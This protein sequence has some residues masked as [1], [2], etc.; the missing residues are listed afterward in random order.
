MFVPRPITIKLWLWFLDG[1]ARDMSEL[2][3]I[4][5]TSII[6]IFFFEWPLEFVFFYSKA[7]DLSVHIYTSYFV[8]Q[9]LFSALPSGK[10][11][12]SWGITKN[13]GTN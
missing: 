4:F 1:K 3:W 10:V 9:W 5:S 12:C 8:L 6:Q 7:S 11:S 2:T 13:R